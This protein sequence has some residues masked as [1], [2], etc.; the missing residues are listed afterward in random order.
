MISV[1]ADWLGE[2][3]THAVPWSMPQARH[4]YG[5]ALD[6]RAAVWLASSDF[7]N[8]WQWVSQT[9]QLRNVGAHASATG[10][11][12]GATGSAAAA[13]APIA[14]ARASQRAGEAL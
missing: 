14:T 8:V 1:G 6:L 10:Y 11:L 5:L 4:L 2:S 9:S 13:L 12:V 7:V 3:G